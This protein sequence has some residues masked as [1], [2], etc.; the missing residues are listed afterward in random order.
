MTKQQTLIYQTL[1]KKPPNIMQKLKTRVEIRCSSCPAS[2]TRHATLF[3]LNV[4]LWKFNK[5]FVSFVITFVEWYWVCGNRDNGL[6]C[7]WLLSK[8]KLRDLSWM[9]I[10]L[11][12]VFLLHDI[13]VSKIMS[14]LLTNMILSCGVT[15]SNTIANFVTTYPK[16][17][18]ALKQSLASNVKWILLIFVV[19]D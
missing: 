18:K 19:I 4:V 3:F 16:H 12:N 13:G 2:G 11:W 5:S 7:E 10:L 8:A 9:S 6:R 17:V 14:A 1:H 15:S